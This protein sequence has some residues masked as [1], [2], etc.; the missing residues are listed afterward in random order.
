M[1]VQT[2]KTVIQIRR[3]TTAEWLEYKHVIPAAGEPCFDLDLN[4][5]RIGNGV[6]S[7]EMLVPIGGVNVDA[8]GKSIILEDGIF[9][10]LGFDA[11]E[12]G[13]QPRK[14]ENGGIEWVVPSDEE[15]KTVIESLETIKEIVMPEGEDGLLDRVEALEDAMGGVD[16]K[17]DE[18]IKAFAELMTPDDK[19]NTLL[20]LINYVEAHNIEVADM[21]AN[22]G[23]LKELVGETSI[24]E[25]IMHILETEQI[26][27]DNVE[28]EVAY[29]P[30]GTLVDM[31]EEEIRIMIPADTG[32]ELQNS[33]AGA[34]PNSYY[35]GFKAYAPDGA[36]SFKEDIS[37]TITDDTMYY[38]EDNEFAGIDENGRKY[39]IIWLPVAKFDG[40]TWTYHGAN[41]SVEKYIGWYYS[42]EWYDENGKVIDADTIRINLSNEICHS[43]IEPYYMGGIKEEIIAVIEESVSEVSD[44][45]IESLFN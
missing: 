14:G 5:L 4:T 40:E 18:K 23:D 6:D 22:I 29:K 20:E 1:A 39:S 15:L 21:E 11:A 2:I 37:E 38:F 36:V 34:D 9:K 45:D 41:S 10:L 30:E 27:I 44:A 25:Q 3:A 19:I 31:R 16:A 12:V 28:Y 32:F 35:I 24:K 8:D 7:Y 42:V 26:A 43:S 13:A 33:G 17:I